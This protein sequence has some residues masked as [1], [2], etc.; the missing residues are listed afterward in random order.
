MKTPTILL[1]DDDEIIQLLFEETLR[2]VSAD[3][4][5]EY[6]R[7]AQEGLNY[8]ISCKEQ[9]TFPRY[10]IVDLKMPVMDG[11][12]FIEQYEKEFYARH[13]QTKLFVLSSSIS[14]KDKTKAF[15][16]DSVRDFV[17]KPLKAEKLSR[18]LED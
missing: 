11:F 16:F 13:P 14:D 9:G 1:I 10:I 2:E 12:E 17:T 3:V 8:L 6:R 4:A 5:Y 15:E 18:L 7:S